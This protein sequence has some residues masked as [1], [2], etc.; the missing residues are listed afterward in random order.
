MKCVLLNGKPGSEISILDRGLQYG[1]GLFETMRVH[2]QSI[3]LWKY[4]WDRLQHGCERLKIPLP[5][6]QL[7]SQEIQ[8]CI[9]ATDHAVLKLILT[10]GIGQRG[11]VIPDRCEVSRIFLLGEIPAYPEQFQKKGVRIHSCKTPLGINPV[12]AGIKHLN[13]LEQILA[14]SEWQGNEYQEGLMCDTNGFVIEGTMSNIFWFYNGTL[15]TPDLTA[16]GVAGV[17]REIVI[18]LAKEQSISIKMGLWSTKELL[19]AEEIFI[20][21]S[22]IGIW[23]V[24]YILNRTFPVGP[25]TQQLQSTLQAKYAI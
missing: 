24:S 10:R 19:K 4:H 3:P 8:Q 2:H 7:L 12:L 6:E 22:L 21:N 18:Q 11:Y 5:D 15:Y 17:M 14:R 23:P 20:S 1:D 16:C 9:S 13:R 25:V